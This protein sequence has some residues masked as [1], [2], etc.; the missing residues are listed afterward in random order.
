MFLSF[1]ICSTFIIN[2]CHE[3]SLDWIIFV[4]SQTPEAI[5]TTA[6][7]VVVIDP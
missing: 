1:I 3:L 2:P 4:M 7:I 6:N 5:V